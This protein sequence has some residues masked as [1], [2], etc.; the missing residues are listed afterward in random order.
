MDTVLP[1]IQDNTSYTGQVANN[2]R[3]SA[4]AMGGGFLGGGAVGGPHGAL[5]GAAGGGIA[6]ITNKTLEA[7]HNVYEAGQALHGAH[8][9]VPDEQ[10]VE[11]GGHRQHRRSQGRNEEVPHGVQGRGGYRRHIL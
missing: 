3:E 4:K 11:D 8:G 5:A 7:G 6:D 2:F 10:D 9:P 1:Q